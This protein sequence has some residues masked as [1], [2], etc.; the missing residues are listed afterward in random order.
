MLPLYLGTLLEWYDFSIFAF[1]AP[2][3]SNLFFPAENQ[4]I[5]VMMTYAIFAIG[6]I[7]RPLGGVFF[8]KYAD[9]EG[10]KKSLLLSMMIMTF[11]TIS[12]G[13]LPTYE[14]VGISASIAMIILRLIQGFSVGGESSGSSTYVIEMYPKK[15]R[16][17]L[18]AIMWSAVGMGMLLG[19]ALSTLIFQLFSM[20]ELMRGYWRIPFL[21]SILTGIIGYYFRRKIPETYLFQAHQCNPE[22]VKK[23]ALIVVKE[24]KRPIVTII[25]LYGLSAIITYVLFV[26]MPVYMSQHNN[27]PLKTAS[28][29]TTVAL[30]IVT[31]LIPFSGYISDLLGRKF[32]LYVGAIGWMILSIPLYRYMNAEKTILSYILSE[33]IFVI[34]AIIYQGALTAAVQ[35]MI[36]T[37]HRFTITSVG[38]NVS[39]GL[40]GGTAPLMIAW[41]S[42]ISAL[43]IMPGIYLAFFACL[44]ISGV[45]RMEETYNAQLQ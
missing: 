22:R 12:I 14:S 27:I 32:C 31:L 35:E 40:I 10:R 30:S 18:S 42:E 9:D 1:L 39:Y 38:Y 6:F 23:K 17:L 11:A 5:S 41:L 33:G 44:A 24:N 20:D 25:L 29:I 19:A 21:I 43:H 26:Y 4:A 45:Y 28:S 3:L 13:L 16:G 8:G 15:Y 34:L 2:V 37:K 36:Q 7:V